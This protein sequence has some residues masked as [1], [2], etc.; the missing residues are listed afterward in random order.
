METEIGP[1][2]KKGPQTHGDYLIIA[3]PTR[4]L[5]YVSE[6]ANVNVN[7]FNSS[8]ITFRPL[9]G[10]VGAENPTPL[11]YLLQ[12]DDVRVLLDCGSPDWSPEQPIH[13]DA[14]CA[15]LRECAS[16]LPS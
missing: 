7:L 2:V 15:A 5:V 6:R 12:V 11:A 4:R 14:Y 13:P 16:S 9:A 10:A 1:R 8:M 3:I